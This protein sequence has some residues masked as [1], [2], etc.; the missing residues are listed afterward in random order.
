MIIRHLHQQS[1]ADWIFVSVRP[2]VGW[3]AGRSVRRLAGCRNE[4][5]SEPFDL[6]AQIKSSEMAERK[7]TIAA[8]AGIRKLKLRWP[9]APFV[10]SFF[11]T[12]NLILAQLECRLCVC[13]SGQKLTFAFPLLVV[14][15]LGCPRCWAPDGCARPMA[16]DKRRRHAARFERRPSLF[17][18]QLSDRRRRSHRI[19]IRSQ[20][21][22]K[23]ETNCDAAGERRTPSIV[24]HS[25]QFARSLVWRVEIRTGNKEF[26]R[27]PSVD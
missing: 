22:L 6:G 7:F 26:N 2:L 3:S 4:S 11:R 20:C 9:A 24:F 19:S 25:L 21:R 1:A 10:E 15:Y 13:L 12:T 5:Q 27:A 16:R 14:I 23:K 18:L 8:A 17:P